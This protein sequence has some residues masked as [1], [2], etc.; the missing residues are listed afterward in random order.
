MSR[1]FSENKERSISLL[2]KA[3]SAL[4]EEIADAGTVV[5]PAKQAK[6]TPIIEVTQESMATPKA[7]EIRM[8]QPRRWGGIAFEAAWRRMARWWR[9]RN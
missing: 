9:G 3:I 2:R 5:E 8:P 7:G 4:E 6:D 1:N